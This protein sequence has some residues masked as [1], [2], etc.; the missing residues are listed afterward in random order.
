MSSFAT[1]SIRKR[2]IAMSS[3]DCSME[4]YSDEVIDGGSQSIYGE[5][6]QQQPIMHNTYPSQLATNNIKTCTAVSPFLDFR[7]NSSVMLSQSSTVSSETFDS[8]IRM[9]FETSPTKTIQQHHS[10]ISDAN[11]DNHSSVSMGSPTWNCSI[12]L[13]PARKRA[14]N[15]GEFGGTSGKLPERGMVCDASVKDPKAKKLC[16][17]HVCGNNATYYSVMLNSMGVDPASSQGSLT[18]MKPKVPKSHSLLNY[19]HKSK[20]PTKRTALFKS[21]IS[22]VT[23]PS[24]LK[25]DDPIN[26][27]YC[28]KPTCSYCTRQCEH[29]SRD[30]CTFCSKVDYGGVTEKILCFECV[31]DR[32]A[33]RFFTDDVIM[34]DL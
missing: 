34:M 20:V 13:E 18:P 4:N 9:D 23:E 31:H 25:H 5:S 29:C 27:Q 14:R 32:E 12:N 1:S 6:A 16:C 30:F 21:S 10:C 22:G 7:R 15:E 33:Q 26:C 3:I 19:F 24:L 11:N 8:L 2:T 17:C 28:D